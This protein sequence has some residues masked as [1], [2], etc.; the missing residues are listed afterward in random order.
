MTLAKALIRNT[1]LQI[2]GKIVSTLLGVVAIA[3]MT[4]SLGSEQFGW[5]VTAT[6][7]LQFVGILIDFGF[8]VTTSNMLSEPDFD[9]EKLF[10]TI[11]T[12]RFFSALFF[13][14]LSPVLIF[15]FPYQSEIKWAA[16]ISS[17]SFFSITVSQVFIGYYRQKLEM[18]Y[19]TVSEILGRIFLVAGISIFANRAGFFAIMLIITLASIISCVYLWFN[20]G[21]VK[22]SFDK[23]ISKAL[24][25]KMWPTATSVIFNTLYLQADR[26]ILP[27]YVTQSEV[28]LYGAAY[29]VLDIVIQISALIMGLIMPLVTFSWSRG[30][31]ED[32]KKRYQL[33]VDL[34]VLVLFPIVVGMFVLSDP[35]MSFIAGEEFVNSGRMLKWLS[36]S[37]L[38]TSFGMIFGHII[39]AINKQRQ[40][41]IIYGSDAVISL[42]AYFIFIPKYGWVGAAAVTIFSEIYAG[43]LLTIFSIYY[44]K[45]FPSFFTVLKIFAASLIMGL[46]LWK[47]H[48]PSLLW[49]IIFGATIYSILILA[50]KVVKTTTIK[51]LFSSNIAES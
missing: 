39:L 43:I 2:G 14:G 46:F 6:G 34:L 28:G 37:V 26:V 23:V 5:Y 17:V 10:N 7:F 51:I 33:G 32:F 12:W 9:K 18:L 22:F 36:I 13:F 29:R 40:A 27:L 21:H 48:L 49:S 1:V 8:T 42:I 11:F 15:L 25:F 30:L 38:G 50:L 20:F 35:I 31:I 19:P 47:I 4:R 3:V 24:F 41:L 16:A 44:S 45:T